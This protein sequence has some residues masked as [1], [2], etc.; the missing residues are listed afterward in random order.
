MVSFDAA[1][2]IVHPSGCSER[3]ESLFFHGVAL[4]DDVLSQTHVC[5]VMSKQH[6]QIIQRNEESMNSDAVDA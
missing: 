3:C 2:R 1:W 6:R 5:V 4:K